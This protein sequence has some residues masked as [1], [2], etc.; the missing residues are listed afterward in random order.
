MISIII[1]LFNEASNVPHL[2]EQIHAAFSEGEFKDSY[3]VIFVDDGSADN[4]LEELK[5]HKKKFKNAHILELSR[6]FGQSNAIM[7]GIAEAKGAYIGILDGDLQN[8]PAEILKLLD[9]IREKK[10]NI[11]YGVRRKRRDCLARRFFAFLHFR[12]LDRLTPYAIPCGISAFRV[13]DRAAVNLLLKLPEKNRVFAVLTSYLGLTYDCVEVNHLPR[14]SGRSKYS[15]M[16]LFSRFIHSLLGFS[17][18]PLRVIAGFG[19]FIALISFVFGIYFFIK[20]IF[21]GTHVRGFTTIVVLIS[22]FSGVQILAVSLVGAYIA[23]IYEE[24]L[25]RPNYIVKNK[26]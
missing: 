21:I 19:L 26:F 14:F 20:K 10:V 23:R 3:E 5:T 15:F 1:P 11:V 24:V 25:D 17:T 22:F 12:I 6:N 13:M 9:R 18:F 4:T 16:Q 8:P 7:A 2:A